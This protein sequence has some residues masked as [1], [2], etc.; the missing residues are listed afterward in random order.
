MSDKIKFFLQELDSLDLRDKAH[1]INEIV[2]S[3]P[4]F[5]S[6][7]AMSE[8]EKKIWSTHYGDLAKAYFSGDLP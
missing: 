7:A 8:T 4:G 6:F 1:L 2:K 3:Y 5:V